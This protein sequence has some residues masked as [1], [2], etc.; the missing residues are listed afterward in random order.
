MSSGFL[1]AQMAIKYFSTQGELLYAPASHPAL[2]IDNN[3]KS[4][5]T[6]SDWQEFIIQYI[7]D[8]PNKDFVVVSNTMNSLVPEIYDFSFF[9]GVQEDK[10]IHFLLDDSHG[11]GILEKEGS[12]VAA[13]IPKRDC[14]RITVVA[15]M[16][17]GLGL[18]AGVILSDRLTIEQLKRTGI[19]TSA[20]PAA[21][22][23]MYTFIHAKDIYK[24]KYD[25]LQRNVA[26]F[27]KHTSKLSISINNF[28]VFYFPNTSLFDHLKKKNIIIS[29]FS[30][31]L[32]INPPLNRVIISSAHREEDIL[33]IS[34]KI[35]IL[36]W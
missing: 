35:N 33:T 10:N 32:P 24:E 21:T 14:F 6:F 22:A 7:N 5:L 18:D 27:R 23:A 26:L 8:S 30:Y 11:I 31:P 3:P 16:A 28:P 25:V 20:S 36:P 29:S 19:Y 15:S 2:W 12:A 4:P 17:K 1:A 9:K 13:N 34:R